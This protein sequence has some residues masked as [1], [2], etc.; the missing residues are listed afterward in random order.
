MFGV[1]HS[2][3]CLV[4]AGSANNRISANN[5]EQAKRENLAASGLG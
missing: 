2:L 4:G 5:G 1:D 3:F